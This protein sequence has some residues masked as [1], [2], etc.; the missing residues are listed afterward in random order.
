[1]LETENAVFRGGA[2]FQSNIPDISNVKMRPYR[3]ARVYR[4]GS[5]KR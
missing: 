4:S 3:V 5:K 2:V 1:M